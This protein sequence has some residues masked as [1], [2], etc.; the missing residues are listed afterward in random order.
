MDDRGEDEDDDSDPAPA[1]TLSDALFAVHTLTT[2][3]EQDFL[4]FK[5][6][7]R[8]VRSLHSKLQHIRVVRA[9]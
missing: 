6:K 3:M 2:F 7:T 9:Q 8:A 1:V 5:D 4:S